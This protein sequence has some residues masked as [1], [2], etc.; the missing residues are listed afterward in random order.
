M[1]DARQ[2]TWGNAE[3]GEQ[4]C[5]SYP[6]VFACMWW[7][8]G[9]SEQDIWLHL[10]CLFMLTLCARLTSYHLK[11]KWHPFCS[12]LAALMNLRAFIDH[13]FSWNP[14]N[15]KWSLAPFFSYIHSALILGHRPLHIN[16]YQMTR[17]VSLSMFCTLVYAT[18]LARS[19]KHLLWNFLYNVTHSWPRVDLKKMH[20]VWQKDYSITKISK[21]VLSTNQTLPSNGMFVLNFLSTWMCSSALLL[22]PG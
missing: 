11:N 5:E 10:L 19:T 12:N 20:R 8:L 13:C 15:Y 14:D 16:G 7:F 3:E 18:N 4:D 22:P 17:V 6:F 1:W 21:V 2:S 9:V